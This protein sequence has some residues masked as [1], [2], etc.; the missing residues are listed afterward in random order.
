MNLKPDSFDIIEFSSA[1]TIMIYY[2]G[3][4]VLKVVVIGVS[5]SNKTLLKVLESAIN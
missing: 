4:A 2:L 1:T 5:L 3:G